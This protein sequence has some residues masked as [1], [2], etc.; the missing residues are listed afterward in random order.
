[1]RALIEFLFGVDLEGWGRGDR[2]GVEWMSAGGG[3]DF[4]F[5]TVV[6]AIALG[7]GDVKM[8][9]EL[10]GTETKAAITTD[11]AGFV[12]INGA[13]P[14]S[15]PVLA[16]EV[17]SI[18]VTGGTENNEIDL[19]GVTDADFFNVTEVVINSGGGDDMII[20]SSL[21]KS[22]RIDAGPGDDTIFG[23]GGND[24]INGGSGD[25]KGCGGCR[26]AARHGRPK[27]IKQILV[28]FR[29]VVEE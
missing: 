28:G 21:L 11:G 5:W 17:G 18:L 1:M 23:N 19:S 16:S 2:W 9:I 4:W 8:K 3:G 29:L 15:G 10:N 22:D 13:E 14:D 25:D 26:P 20:G 6:V 27:G 24:T 12:L 7:F